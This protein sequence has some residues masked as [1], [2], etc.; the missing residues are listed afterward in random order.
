MSARF[1]QVGHSFSVPLRQV[2][3]R[4]LWGARLTSFVGD[5]VVEV[6]LP[7]A[8]LEVGH[9]ARAVGFV[10]AATYAPNLLFILAGGVWADRLPRVRVMV[11]ADV[12]RG[13]AQATTAILLFSGAAR[14]WQLALLGAVY[15]LG[16][17]FFAPA[18]TAIVPETVTADALQD[19]NAL[20]NLTQSGVGIIGPALGGIL[21]AAAGPASAFAL[22]ATSFGIGTLLLLRM[23]VGARP[24]AEPEGF[25]TSVRR[26]WVEVRTRTWVAAAIGTF[27]VWN[28]A[29][30]SYFVLGPTVADRDLGGAGA[31]GAILACG[32]IGSIA[33][34]LISLRWR[35][36]RP[37]GAAFLLVGLCALPLLGLAAPAPTAI[38]AAANLVAWAG[39]A[40]ANTLW[41]TTLHVHVPADSLARVSSYDWL[42]SL[43]FQPIGLAVAGPLAV[44]IGTGVTLSGAALAVLVTPLVFLVAFADIRRLSAATA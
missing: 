31:W 27:S 8:A 29:F 23:P 1:L 24:A 21:V 16:T 18:S 13:A 25:L 43:I 38:I 30:A 32:S 11:G 39:L 6:A 33:G 19:A 4:R 34:G 22:D 3:F 9:S 14:L 26:G 36:E 10:L 40:I 28:L 12:I 41:Y 37:L 15:G 5:R 35:P 2:P 42:G 44:A 17:A 7:F 20:L